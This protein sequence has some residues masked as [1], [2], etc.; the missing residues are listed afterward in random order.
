MKEKTCIICMDS[1]KN[2][3][4]PCLCSGGYYHEKCLV[5]WLESRTDGVI[6]CEICDSEYTGIIVKTYYIY[7]LHVFIYS[8][9]MI[10][11]LT[12]LFIKKPISTYICVFIVSILLLIYIFLDYDCIKK[13]KEAKKVIKIYKR[14]DI[15]GPSIE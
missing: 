6:G 4:K 10:G 11:I 15:I 8:M 12:I 2:L 14:N 13:Y 1:G 5:E 3:V 7:R 9:V